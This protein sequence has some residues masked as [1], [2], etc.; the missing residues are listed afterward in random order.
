MLATALPL[1]VM[2]P[3]ETGAAAWRRFLVEKR[4]NAGR[5]PIAELLEHLHEQW[6]DEGRLSSARS[7]RSAITHQ[8]GPAFGPMPCADIR[9]EYIAAW[10]QALLAE[11]RPGKTVRKVVSFLSS[12]LTLAVK[13]GGLEVNPV[14]LLP[15]GSLPSNRAKDPTRPALETLDYKHVA[16]VL[17]GRAELGDMHWVLW[18]LLLLTGARFGEAAA[19]RWKDI[20]RGHALRIERSW[21]SKARVEG[22]G[23]TD[24][25]RHVPISAHLEPVLDVAAQLTQA[26]AGRPIEPEDL[27]APYFDKADHTLRHWQNATANRRWKKAQKVLGWSLPPTGPRT[28][29]ATRHTFTTLCR[30]AGGD[31]AATHMIT[32]ASEPDSRTSARVY[33]HLDFA[34][35]RAVVAKL[36]ARIASAL[37][38]TDDR[39]EGP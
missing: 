20:S 13:L 19:L 30:R 18:C 17:Q 38:D 39:P 3:P 35:L 2:P 28:V 25:V 12:A 29:K 24:L 7:L 6:V 11:G 21:D 8:I 15:P 10:I 16:D 22:P 36:D 14:R 37:E 26:R 9:P 32:H 4:P 33:T 1:E 34:D 5:I 31:I 27:V 23:K